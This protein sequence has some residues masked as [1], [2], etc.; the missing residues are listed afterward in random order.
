MKHFV[1]MMGPPGGGKGTQARILSAKLQVPHLSTGEM[2]RA[3][4]KDGT[5][6]GCRIK[7][8]VDEGKLVPDE[9]AISCIREKMADYSYAKGFIFDGFPRTVQ[10]A[11]AFDRLLDEFNIRIDIVIDI[12]VPDDYIIQ[13]VTGRFA[14]GKCGAGYHDIFKPTIVKGVC[15]VCGGTAFI[16]RP[17]DNKETVTER[18]VQYR[19][20]TTPVLPYYEKEGL[21]VCVDG[22]GP[23][24]SVAGKI[25]R[26]VGL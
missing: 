1:V 6:V 3:A 18:L 7:D 21:L 19:A 23:I 22:T 25:D 24:D 26:V 11:E 10:Q 13:R 15:D 2:F 20:M 9:L 16:R 12:Q 17:D 8:L 14:C 4:I 5:D